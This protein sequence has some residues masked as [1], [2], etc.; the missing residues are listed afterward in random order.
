MDRLQAER[1]L[2]QR[3]GVS[4]HDPSL[5]GLALTHRSFLHERPGEAAESNERLEFLGDAFLG[6]VAGE[7]LFR[8]FP[9][10]PEGRLTEMR[11]HLVRT[12]TLARIAVELEVGPALLL[13]HGEELSGGRRRERNLARALEAI[14]G[15]LFVDQGYV[16]ARQVTLMLFEEL[17]APL[18]D[19][20]VRDDK[21]LL[22]EMVQSQGKPA[23]AYHTIGQVGPD[24]TKVFTVEVRVDGEALARGSGASKR[25]AEQ[26]AAREA[27]ELLASVA[28]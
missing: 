1:A 4:F 18:A 7:E 23:P 22:Q 15:A 14:L 25:K 5:L 8:R 11:S 2:E 13:G 16:D 10:L 19:A 26:A 17:L 28:E 9:E 24:H 20:S 12:G 21:S 6:L 27:Y 3:L